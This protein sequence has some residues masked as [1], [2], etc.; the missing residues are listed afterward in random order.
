MVEGRKLAGE[1]EFLHLFSN[2]HRIR[3][4]P[5]PQESGRLPILLSTE[6]RSHPHFFLT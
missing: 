3:T 2:M 5:P 6:E 1:G 4:P